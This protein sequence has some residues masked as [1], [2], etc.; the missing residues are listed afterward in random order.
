MLPANIQDLN[1]Q[2]KPSS[3]LK[4]HKGASGS[5]AGRDAV[6]AK[7]KYCRADVSVWARAKH[8]HLDIVSGNEMQSSLGKPGTSV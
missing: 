1:C 4:M 5:T 6:V 7:L 8:S 2:H 3:N